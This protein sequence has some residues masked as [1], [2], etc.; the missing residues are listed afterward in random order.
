MTGPMEDRVEGGELHRVEAIRRDL[1]A[2]EELPV[3]ER[4]AAFSA[5]NEA[6]VAQL[7]AM[8]EV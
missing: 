8:E 5:L 3:E 2:A 4:A 7:N 6:I 1:E